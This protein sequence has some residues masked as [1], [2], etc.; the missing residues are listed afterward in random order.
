MTLLEKYQENH[1]DLNE[2]LERIDEKSRKKFIKKLKREKDKSNFIAIVT[3]L[4]CYEFFFNSGFKVEFERGYSVGSKRLTP[5]FTIS[6][7]GQDAIVEVVRLNPTEKDSKRNN[8]ESLLMEGIEELKK[9]CVIKIDFI[10][11]Y[12]DE[13][14]YDI[15]SIVNDLEIWLEQSFYLNSKITLCDNFRFEIIDIN[16]IYDHACVYGNFN[17]IDIDPRRLKSDKS[18]FVSKLEKYDE[19]IQ[20]YNLPYVVFIKIDFHAGINE[21]EMF[22]TMY[23]DSLLYDHLN[24]RESALNGLFY[25]NKIGKENVSGVLLIVGSKASYYK[26]FYFLNKLSKEIDD[27]FGKMQ[28]F[29]DVPNKFVYLRGVRKNG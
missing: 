4:Q 17:S 12:F 27:E 11:E 14:L 5:D 26:N 25:A 3:E 2:R 20:H 8:F 10:N 29:S 23:G 16:D 28:F 18:L 15:K 21:N 13:D 19:L 22:W 7:N 24:K 9:K 1:P 6:K